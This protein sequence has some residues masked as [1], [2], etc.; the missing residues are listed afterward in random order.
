MDQ[1]LFQLLA[2]ARVLESFYRC[3][4]LIHHSILQWDNGEESSLWRRMAQSLWRSTQNTPS[5]LG[6]RAKGRL[7]NV[8]AH[9]VD[10]NDHC[11]SLISQS[12]FVLCM[13]ASLAQ[14][15][16]RMLLGEE[17]AIDALC[18]LS[19]RGHLWG[20]D[21]ESMADYMAR[22][23]SQY[24]MLLYLERTVARLGSASVLRQYHQSSNVLRSFSPENSRDIVTA[25]QDDLVPFEH[26]QQAVQFLR[27]RFDLGMQWVPGFYAPSSALPTLAGACSYATNLGCFIQLHGGLKRSERTRV[28]GNLVALDRDEL[29]QHEL[30]HA[31]RTALEST[32]FEEEFAY[33][34]STSR[35]RQTIAP[36]AQN[37]SDITAFTALSLLNMA[38]D[39]PIFSRR[40][41]LLAKLS[42]LGMTS[43]AVGRLILTK[44]TL[45]H[46]AHCLQ[47]VFRGNVT[48]IANMDRRVH[49]IL[50]RLTDND[51]NELAELWR[52]GQKNDDRRTIFEE[53]NRL[54]IKNCSRTMRWRI[55]NQCYLHLTV[56]E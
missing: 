7:R 47:S 9:L 54:V 55:I 39:L 30:I 51:I 28:V 37:P 10:T 6:S 35:M 42:M 33:S 8:L 53:F 52:R 13:D 31:A 26:I 41:S 49:H 40:A 4:A 29:I 17:V 27:D 19:K 21:Q 24:R 1:R 11:E 56:P 22:V 38:S 2:I 16:N 44:R 43:L 25:L 5:S 50:I 12:Q 46:A 48:D 36:I 23:V 14:T 3:G 20:N 34:T 32:R 15:V 18:E 45:R